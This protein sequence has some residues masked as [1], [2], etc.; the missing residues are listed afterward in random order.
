MFAVD[1]FFDEISRRITSLHGVHMRLGGKI[2]AS[3]HLTN[4][5]HA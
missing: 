4:R 3:T 2:I 5:K 1:L